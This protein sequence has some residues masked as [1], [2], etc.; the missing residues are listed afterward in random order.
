[1]ETYW[2]WQKFYKIKPMKFPSKFPN[3]TFNRPKKK[4]D[5]PTILYT[6]NQQF[7]FYFQLFTIFFSL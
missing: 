4:N 1:M 2:I 5:F 7:K 6:L 3:F